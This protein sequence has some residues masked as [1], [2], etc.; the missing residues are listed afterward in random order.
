VVGVSPEALV[1]IPFSRITLTAVS[2]QVRTRRGGQASTLSAPVSCAWIAMSGDG[3]RVAVQSA[4]SQLFR[5]DGGAPWTELAEAPVPTASGLPPI[6]VLGFDTAGKLFVI[7]NTAG[8][9]SGADAVDY[10]LGRE[11]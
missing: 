4:S 8:D 5:S 7:T 9:G 3:D 6:R 2:I 1:E 10:L 11:P